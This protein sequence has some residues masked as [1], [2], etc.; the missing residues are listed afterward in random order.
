MNR[1][2]IFFLLPLLLCWGCGLTNHRDETNIEGSWTLYDVTTQNPGSVDFNTEASLKGSLE[3]GSILSFFKDSSFTKAEGNGDFALGSWRRSKEE[4]EIALTIR[5]GEKKQ[6]RVTVEPPSGEHRSVALVIRRDSFIYKYIQTAAP[7]P[8]Y[9]NDPFYTTNNRWRL[10]PKEEED[11]TH[12]RERLANYFKHLALLLKAAKDRQQTVVTFQFSQGPVKIYNG[13]IGIL[14]YSKVKRC[15][16][17]GFFNDDAAAYAY[18]LYG[19]YLS[20]AHPMGT[21]TGDWIEDDY[22]ILVSLYPAFHAGIK[23]PTI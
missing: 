14:P 22:R 13:G 4:N 18:W 9:K 16:K 23:K 5:R 1:N 21:G 11:S 19:N 8:D 17:N 7:L 20:E 12:V 10:T 15:W 2:R 6:I 3:V